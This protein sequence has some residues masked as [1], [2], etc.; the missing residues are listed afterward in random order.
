MA[1]KSVRL[2]VRIA[3]A[4]TQSETYCLLRSI[5]LATALSVLLSSISP[6]ADTTAF[7]CPSFDGDYQMET[8]FLRHA[9][10]R[11]RR[12]DKRQIEVA[13]Q[14]GKRVFRDKPPYD[15]ALSGVGCA[16]CGYDPTLRLLLFTGILLDDRTGSLFPGGH[17]VLFS[18]DQRYYLTFE[19]EDGDVTELG[20]PADRN[21][22]IPRRSWPA[23]KEM[24]T[25]TYVA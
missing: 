17:S 25:A 14:G 6:A 8:E 19:M 12:I 2:A 5:I 1:L 13:W 11:A 18:P 4:P 7:R 10:S 16:Y 15:E 20:T 21:R 23:A 3:F 9:P 24:K 22:R